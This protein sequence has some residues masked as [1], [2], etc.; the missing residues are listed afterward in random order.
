ME[1]RREHT[2][3]MC[4]DGVRREHTLVMC[5]DGVSQGAD[6]GAH[7]YTGVLFAGSVQ[8]P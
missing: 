6:S 3:V 2:L 1:C 7:F 4:M 8:Q 5:M